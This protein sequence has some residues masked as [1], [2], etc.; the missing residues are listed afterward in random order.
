MT[1]VS[2]IADCQ[3]GCPVEFFSLAGKHVG[4]SLILFPGSL[5]ASAEAEQ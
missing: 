5:V 2:G 3:H 1:K 4:R